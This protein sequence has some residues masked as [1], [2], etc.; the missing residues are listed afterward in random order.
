M[1]S[2]MWNCPHSNTVWLSYIKHI[3]AIKILI[4]YR[5]E[6]YT[7]ILRIFL[8]RHMPS[9]F[10]YRVPSDMLHTSPKMAEV[11]ALSYDRHGDSYYEDTSVADLGKVFKKVQSEV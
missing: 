10:H 9:Y 1:K 6:I 2:T 3:C 11:F 8:T 4:E 7:R 5:Q